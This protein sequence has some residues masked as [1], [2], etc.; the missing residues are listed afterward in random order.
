MERLFS[1][2]L[3]I[4]LAGNRTIVADFNGTRVEQFQIFKKHFQLEK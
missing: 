4:L 2:P 3:T 1:P